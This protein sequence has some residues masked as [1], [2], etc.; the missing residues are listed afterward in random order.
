MFAAVLG[1]LGIANRKV[2][3][4]GHRKPPTLHEI[5]R[6]RKRSKLIE[7]PNAM[8]FLYRTPNWKPGQQGARE[9]ARRVRQMQS[10]ALNYT[11]GVDRSV[12]LFAMRA[13]YQDQLDAAFEQ[14]AA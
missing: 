10:G 11:N 3:A 1:A 4:D 7:T 9:C 2:L 5:V 12:N 8:K 6:G 13:A 14:E